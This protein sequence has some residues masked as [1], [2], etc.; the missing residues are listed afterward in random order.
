MPKPVCI[1]C[2]RFYRVKR[3]GMPWVECMP[4]P[5]DAS[6][7]LRRGVG[8]DNQWEPYKLWQ[9]DLWICEGCGHELLVGHGQAPMSEHY[10]PGFDTECHRS[11]VH[12]YVNDC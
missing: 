7:T 10:M 9:S 6:A 5:H 4:R 11:G 2:K 1:K 12:I 8:A 3:N